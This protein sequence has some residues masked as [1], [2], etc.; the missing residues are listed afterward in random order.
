MKKTYTWEKI[1]KKLYSIGWSPRHLVELLS[2]IRK[3]TKKELITWDNINES[4]M[5]MG[6]SPKRILRV[7]IE[8]EDVEDT[9]MKK[10]T[11]KEH[12]ELH[13]KPDN[14]HLNNPS[15]CCNAEMTKDGMC[16]N[17]GDDGRQK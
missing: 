7:L 2:A 8:I 5:N 11:E 6:R 17:C 12:K 14:L 4:L 13:C 1:N 9:S 16:L 3:V 10:L 15:S